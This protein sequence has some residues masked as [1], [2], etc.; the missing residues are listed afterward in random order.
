MRFLTLHLCSIECHVD[1][2][3]INKRILKTAQT[4]RTAFRSPQCQSMSGLSDQGAIN[5]AMAA[6]KAVFF[7]FFVFILF[8][9]YLI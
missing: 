6:E 5:L 8:L 1:P 2:N 3:I 9:F 7:L 4:P